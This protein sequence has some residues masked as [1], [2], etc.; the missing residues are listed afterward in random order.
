MSPVRK[1]EPKAPAKAAAPKKAAPKAESPK[2]AAA[3]KVAAKAPAKAAPVAK[4]VPA[5]KVPAA[6]APAKVAAPKTAA[7]APAKAAPAAKAEPAK[8]A[9]AKAAPAKA[10]PAAR[11]GTLREVFFE[12]YAP[13]TGSVAV[14][15]EFSGWDP[16]PLSKG[17]DGVWRGVVL[18]APGSYQFRLV[19]DGSWEFD[20]SRETVEGPHGLNNLLVVT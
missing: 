14:A 10:A 2:K 13:A 8:K 1:S 7:K 11:K 16:V 4:A 9:V 3:P 17:D 15:G 19:F 12:K 5:P 18:I 20:P 6:K